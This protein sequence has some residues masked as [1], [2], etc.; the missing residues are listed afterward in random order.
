MIASV[1]ESVGRIM[2][3]LDELKLSDRTVVIFTSDNVESVGISAKDWKKAGDITDNA[4]LR[5]GKGSLYEGGTRVPLIVRWPGVTTA[6]SRIQRA[7]HP[8]RHLSHAAR[9]LQSQDTE[10]NARW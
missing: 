10:A 9:D 8:R 6:G 5:S 1:D 7:N 3:K 4:P 2:Q